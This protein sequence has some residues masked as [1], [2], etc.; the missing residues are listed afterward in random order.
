MTL[1]SVEKS[2]A[3][4]EETLDIFIKTGQKDLIEISIGAKMALGILS[5]NKSDEASALRI[6]V[7]DLIRKT[8]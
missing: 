6:R 5:D 7:L 4:L 3:L 8:D 2:I 1:E